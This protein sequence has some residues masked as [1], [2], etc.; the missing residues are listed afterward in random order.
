LTSQFINKCLGLKIYNVIRVRKSYNITN[1]KDIILEW[2]DYK[3][4]FKAYESVFDMPGVKQ[5]LRYVK[6]ANNIEKR[7]PFSNACCHN[8]YDDDH[9]NI[10]QNNQSK[11]E[12][13]G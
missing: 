12:Y 3:Y 9:K 5:Q 8:S 4:R 1:T 7:W 13:R 6:F 10:A 2:N 11:M